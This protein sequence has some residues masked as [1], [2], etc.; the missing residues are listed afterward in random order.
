MHF[1]FTPVFK[2]RNYFITFQHIV[3]ALQSEDLTS[4]ELQKSNYAIFHNVKNLEKKIQNS[5]FTTGQIESLTVSKDSINI[6]YIHCNITDTIIKN[7]IQILRKRYPTR[8]INIFL[9][10]NDNNAISVNAKNVDIYQSNEKSIIINDSL[11]PVLSDPIMSKLSIDTIEFYDMTIDL[12]H[13]IFKTLKTVGSQKWFYK[14]NVHFVQCILFAENELQEAMSAISSNNL[15]EKISK[16]FIDTYGVKDPHGVDWSSIKIDRARPNSLGYLIEN[17][18]KQKLLTEF[19]NLKKTKHERIVISNTNFATLLANDTNRIMLQSILLQAN[20]VRFKN[21]TF[22]KNAAQVIRQVSLNHK[23]IM[24]IDMKDSINASRY[25]DNDSYEIMSELFKPKIRAPNPMDIFSEIFNIS[26]EQSPN[27]NV[28]HNKT[29]SPP[30]NDAVLR[31]AREYAD[32]FPDTHERKKAINTLIDKAQKEDMNP[33]GSHISKSKLEWISNLPRGL[34]EAVKNINELKHLES[35]FWKIMN[36]TFIGNEKVKTEIIKHLILGIKEGK[37]KQW[38]L[39]VGPPG[40]GKTLSISSVAMCVY[41]FN[42]WYQTKYLKMHNNMSEEEILKKVFDKT[43]P[44]LGWIRM[45]SIT[46]ADSI[47]GYD[48]VYMNSRPSDITKALASGHDEEIVECGVIGIDEID[49]SN[50]DQKT[51]NNIAYTLLDKADNSGERFID[52]YLRE[53]TMNLKKMA[54]VVATANSITGI[55]ESIR[56]RFKIITLSGYTISERVEI[57]KNQQIPEKLKSLDLEPDAIRFEDDALRTLVENSSDKLSMR[58]VE[59]DV[60]TVL[61]KAYEL[62]INGGKKQLTVNVELMKDLLPSSVDIL[63]TQRHTINNSGEVVVY[64]ADKEGSI[65][66][67]KIT[68]EKVSKEYSNNHQYDFVGANPIETNSS[69]KHNMANELRLLLTTA[70]PKALKDNQY[71][72]IANPLKHH[73]FVVQIHKDGGIKAAEYTNLA[74]SIGVAVISLLKETQLKQTCY[75]LGAIDNQGRIQLPENKDISSKI[76]SAL[77]Y[78]KRHRPHEKLMIVINRFYKDKNDKQLLDILYSILA[79]DN[80]SRNEV[81]VV[82]ADN[83]IQAYEACVIKNQQTNNSNLKQLVN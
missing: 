68:V 15:S 82:F 14:S 52:I 7:I 57:I 56:D 20:Q 54:F 12:K 41:Y 21:C 51:N 61:E 24:F 18:T 65:V 1:L 16:R 72:S 74:L 28:S 80:I 79:K 76:K 4:C 31:K 26:M 60:S 33:Q 42:L 66:P 17:L 38:I 9:S 3:C 19:A 75:C 64:I 69:E 10:S 48:P 43:N 46:S 45:N 44:N 70:I 78:L 58:G 49:K 32:S 2:M 36:K 27:A 25:Q 40:I 35:V 63:Y 55:P 6:C 34:I 67:V 22:N 5:N 50:N 83:L 29:Q 13:R 77:N 62:Y 37:F 73:I 11:L 59:S 8:K 23:N 30:N 53:I 47:I 71:E 81:D 39:L